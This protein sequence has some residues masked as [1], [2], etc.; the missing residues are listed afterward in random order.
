[1]ADKVLPAVLPWLAWTRID[2]RISPSMTTIRHL[3]PTL[4]II[5]DERWWQNRMALSTLR[6]MREDEGIVRIECVSVYIR[7]SFSS[8]LPTLL[9]GPTNSHIERQVR[10]KQTHPFSS[11]HKERQL[12][13]SESASTRSRR[14]SRSPLPRID[15]Y[16]RPCSRDQSMQRSRS[17]KEIIPNGP[18]ISQS[19][20]FPQQGWCS[21]HPLSGQT[22]SLAPLPPLALALFQMANK[23]RQETDY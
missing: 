20:V 9:R 21:D 3:C 22:I 23:D 15:H 10:N 5:G 11:S 12:Y 19:G 18:T 1:M 16:P 8:S 7:Y 4:G 6:N 13:T 2:W 17:P 14:R